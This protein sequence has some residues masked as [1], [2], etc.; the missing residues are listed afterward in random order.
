M[1][2]QEIVKSFG[3]SYKEGYVDLLY[4]N[5]NILV[6]RRWLGVPAL[7][8]PVPDMWLCGYI[9]FS[10][11]DDVV[12]DAI[13]QLN[14]HGLEVT[15]A[16]D[17]KDQVVIGVDTMDV[18]SGWGATEEDGKKLYDLLQDV[19]RKAIEKEVTK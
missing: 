6:I 9:T 11:D 14:D 12:N 10:K 4:H 19:Y 15:Y 8:M 16:E 1:T 7:L 18:S 2:T 5:D 17:V 13:R 3:A